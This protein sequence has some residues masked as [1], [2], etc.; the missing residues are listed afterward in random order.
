MNIFFLTLELF[1]YGFAIY[2]QIYKKELGF[3]YLPALFFIFTIITPVLPIGVFYALTGLQVLSVFNKRSD[4]LSQNVWSVL[5]IFYFLILLT[6]AAAGIKYSHV[7]SVL[8]LFISIPLINL[9]YKHY[10]YEQVFAELSRSAILV[11]LVFV[12]NAVLSTVTKYNPQSMY[13][14]NS[15]VLYGNLGYTDFNVIGI[16]LF[17][18]LLSILKKNNWLILALYIVALAFVMLTLRRSAMLVSGLSVVFAFFTVMNQRNIGKVTLYMLIAA[19]IGTVVYIKSDFSLVFK[20]RYEMRKLDER[21][22]EEEKRFTEYEMIY[23]DMFVLNKYSPWFGYGLFNSAG[24]YGEG[25][26]E[27]RTLHADLTSIAH[28]SGLIG[29]FLYLMM[30][31]AAFYKALGACRTRGQLLTVCFCFIVFVVYTITG[32]Y[33]QTD[34]MLMLF[35]V[36]NLAI[37]RQQ[38]EV[39]YME[40]DEALVQKSVLQ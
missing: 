29:L 32:R 30:M 24:N 27:D 37:T 25:K 35:L 33:T 9:I 18:V 17:V 12:A 4:L 8:L 28:S 26:F 23:K 15:G 31:A 20:E 6:A 22:F 11:L 10:T 14:I 5:L 3:V 36:C 16:A 7:F 34:A 39:A 2:L 40:Y 38:E 19:L 21:E 1:L 13:G